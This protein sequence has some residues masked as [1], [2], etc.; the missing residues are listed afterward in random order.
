MSTKAHINTRTED[1]TT[2]FSS[3]NRKADSFLD[4]Q[5]QKEL[6][7]LNEQMILTNMDKKRT[8]FNSIV[9]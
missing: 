1:E 7:E 9:P 3:N 2:H 5:H 8:Y 6:I 4:R